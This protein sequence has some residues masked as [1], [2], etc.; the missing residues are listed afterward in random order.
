[1]SDYRLGIPLSGVTAGYPG[2]HA[3]NTNIFPQL[4]EAAT[5]CIQ[6]FCMVK[7]GENVLVVAE[8][9]TDP[10][11]VASMSSAATLAGAEVAVITVPP[12]PAGGY[13][14]G[15]PSNMLVGAYEQSD[16]V[17][18]C[19]YFE[20]AHNERTFFSKI[21]S[22]K[23]RVCSILM[24]STPG[25]LVT[26]GRFP[27][28]LLTAIGNRMNEKMEKCKTVRYTTDSGTDITF[29]G[30]QG[31]AHMTP[32]RTGSWGIFP[33]MGINFYPETSNGVFVFDEATLIG[34][35]RQPVKITVKD[36]FVCGV[37]AG[38]KADADIIAAFSNGK[39]YVRHT[40]IGL[41]PKTRMNNAPQFERERAAGTSYL[42]ID[43]TG[44]DGE[45]DLQAPG[46]AHLDVIFDTPTVYLDDEVVVDRRKLLVLEDE[47]IRKLASKYGDP[48]R[49]LAQNS[50][51][52]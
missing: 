49:V 44:P 10:F 15:T 36:N 35:P 17:I 30:L 41:N 21:F 48:R 5:N 18:A 50:F 37:E 40:V 43:G 13:L 9:D 22:G 27:M 1:M 26:G 39:Y 24:G 46:F 23:K 33:S 19:T 25:C 4:M 34:K 2:H 51:I 8:P 12:F 14:H 16:V 20:F 31:I 6:N 29:E 32:L 38:A 42:G 52:W 45:A 7:P 47:D 11:V 28:E 3:S